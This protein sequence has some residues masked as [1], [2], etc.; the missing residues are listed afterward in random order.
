M[1]PEVAA[2][3]TEHLYAREAPFRYGCGTLLL[4]RHE[5]W[6]RGTPLLPG[7]LRVV[8]NLTFRKEGAEWVSQLPAGW[9]WAMYRR[10]MQMERLVAAASVDARCVLGF[11]AP[12]HP[13]RTHAT[14]AAVKARYEPLGMD[15]APYEVPVDE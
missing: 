14:V 15:M 13:Y 3:R 12:G 6:R 11:P 5:M 8:A 4:Y 7:A 9:A 1:P 2:F 10:G